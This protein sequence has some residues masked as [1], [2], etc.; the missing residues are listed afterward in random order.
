MKLID[1]F[2]TLRN[3]RRDPIGFI[4]EL[5]RQQGHQARLNV[6]GKEL[7][8]LSHPEDVLHVLKGN[9][10]HY[11][12]GRTTKELRKFLGQ[13]LITNEGDSWR[14]QH[15]LIR[16]IMNPKSIFNLAPKIHETCGQ[17]FHELEPD[18]ELNGFH[19]MNRLTWR[20]I[21]RTLFSQEPTAE[22][23]QWLGDILQL[24]H[25]IT[26][27]TRSALPLPFWV[28]TKDHRELKRIIG[29][30]DEYVYS[31]IRS[32]R[33][34][35]EEQDLIQRLIDAQEEGGTMTDLEIRD[36]IMTFLMAGH[37]TITN[38]MS[39][40]L[41]EL[42]RHP[43]Y[44]EQVRAEAEGFMQRPDYEAL[45]GLPWMTAVI[46]ETMRLWP[47]V[48]VF[49][50]QADKPDK[51]GELEIKVK[52]NVVVAPYLTHRSPDLWSNPEAF[53]PERFLPEARKAIV[54]GAF[55]PFGLGPRACIGAYFAGIEAK[56][57]LAHLAHNFDWSIIG[58][59]AQSYEPGI[60][61]RPT[62]NVRMRFKR[63]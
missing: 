58:P 16:P 3:Y 40:L 13:G 37:E 49:M 6:F 5:K 27:K 63:R 34:G 8:I 47:P 42:A 28:P 20:I 10:S 57:I 21:L 12:K 50:R 15:R 56:I 60:T 53:Y 43:Q 55:Y 14:K 4:S 35:G 44:L 36:E 51:I 38:S 26:S 31:L 7:F 18:K 17:F 61:L 54:P 11:S 9:H 30:F 29:K 22:M 41:I 23:D 19:E 32:R 1:S 52:A 48:W 33:Q 2:K 45:A 24:M 59:E 46:D 25:I 39:W 62:N